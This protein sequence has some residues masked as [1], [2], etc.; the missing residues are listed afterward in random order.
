M[1]YS[2]DELT[3]AMTADEVETAIYDALGVRKAAT[4]TWKTGSVVRTIIAG[5]A[6]VLAAFSSLS[7]LVAA[8]GFMELATEDWLTLLAD[9][10]FGVER[11]DG[12]YATGDVRFTNASGTPAVATSRTRRTTPGRA[13]IPP[14]ATRAARAL[15]L[16][17]MMVSIR[18]PHS[19]CGGGW[20]AAAPE[21]SVK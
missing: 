12:T 2:L 6:R 18:S 17:S 21:Y 14:A 13:R 10:V 20:W 15:P 9:Y 8:G 7:A 3:T 4:T 5:V 11:I 16:L 1:T 19:R